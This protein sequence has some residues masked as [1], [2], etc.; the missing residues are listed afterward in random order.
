MAF[1]SGNDPV[2]EETVQ[3]ESASSHRRMNCGLSLLLLGVKK[4]MQE[5]KALVF[6]YET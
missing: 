6:V 5:W 4:R 1:I 2:R 3:N